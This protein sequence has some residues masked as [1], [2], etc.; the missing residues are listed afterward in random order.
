[1]LVN[2]FLT[3]ASDVAE[4]NKAYATAFGPA[5]YP[6]RTTIIV[7]GLPDREM[8]VELDCVVEIPA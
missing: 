2:V 1:M 5:P 6:A 3:R 8:P 7:A 4:M